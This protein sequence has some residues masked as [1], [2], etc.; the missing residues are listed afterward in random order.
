MNRGILT[1]RNQALWLFSS[2]AGAALLQAALLILLARSVAPATFGLVNAAQ[3]ALQFGGVVFDAGLT[4]Y[5]V[6]AYAID[7]RLVHAYKALDLNALL[8][9]TFVILAILIAVILLRDW[10]T[11]AAIGGVATWVGF[12]KVC[13]ARASLFIA[14]QR[15][16][17]PAVSPIIRRVVA[18]AGFIGLSRIADPALS[19]ALALSLGGVAGYVYLLGRMRALPTRDKAVPCRAADVLRDSLPFGVSNLFSQAKNLDAAVVAAAT[20]AAAAGAYAAASRLSAPVFLATSAVATSVMPA[21]GRRGAE[22]TRKLAV[23]LVLAGG[24]QVLLAVLLTPWAGSLVTLLYGEGYT[25]LGP[26]FV[27]VLCGTILNSL[28]SPFNALLQSV[29]REKLVAALSVWF[30]VLLLAGIWSG[31]ANFGIYGAAWGY[32][33][34]N[35]LNLAVQVPVTFVYSGGRV[36]TLERSAV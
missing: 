15:G 11:L 30:G 16:I 7:G 19:Y 34:A 25:G 6:R 17:E 22:I 13:E 33:A 5:I 36:A 3:G 21:V 23:G 4:A 24:A 28:Q 27:V 29:G 31:A 35:I 20:G 2:R 1:M 9:S 14:E 10:L 26:L 32:V 18:L 12:E 8:T